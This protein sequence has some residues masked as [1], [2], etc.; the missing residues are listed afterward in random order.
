MPWD[1]DDLAQLTSPRNPDAELAAVFDRSRPGRPPSTRYDV[2]SISLL[3]VWAD[4]AG[5]L[6]TGD[7]G[8][9]AWA[10][11]PCRGLVPTVGSTT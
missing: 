1:V 10:Q 2:D 6:S 4:S 9:D 11:T 8:P 7:V 3:P 5:A